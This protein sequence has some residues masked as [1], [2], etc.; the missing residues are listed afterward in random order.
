[1]I[2]PADANETVAAWKVAVATEGPTA[3]VLSRQNLTVC[4][5]GSAVERGAA[6]I[7]DAAG[8]KVVLLATGSE[9]PL[10]VEAA[11][12]LAAAGIAARV[13]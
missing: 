10:C 13:V 12:A 8:A 9:V 4:T 7:R 1:M 5:D 11:E 6:V 2:R 3:L